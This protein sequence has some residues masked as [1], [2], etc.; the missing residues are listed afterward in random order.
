MQDFKNCNY[1]LNFDE[2]PEKIRDVI[3]GGYSIYII[4]NGEF[5]DINRATV[6]AVDKK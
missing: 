6:P 1:T 3:R 2:I 5:Y 4:I